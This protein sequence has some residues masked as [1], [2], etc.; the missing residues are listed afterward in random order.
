MNT[1]TTTATLSRSDVVAFAWLMVRAAKLPFGD[2]SKKAWAT[3]RLQAQMQQ[4]PVSFFY[5]KD[6]GT[7]RFAVGDKIEAPTPTKTPPTGKPANALVVRYYDTLAG[8]W[9]SFRADRLIVA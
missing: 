5:R 8:G 9:R 2:A 3:R 4:K 6:D 1:V 7:E